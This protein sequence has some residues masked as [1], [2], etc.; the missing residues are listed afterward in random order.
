[1]P[2]EVIHSSEQFSSNYPEQT[3]IVEVRWGR[4]SEY[5]QIAT[6]LVDTQTHEPIER[7]VDGGWFISLNRT[8]INDLIRYLRKA[9]DQAFGRDE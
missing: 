5:A 9:R 4:E 2:K 3:S 7:S 8:G 1:M 6:L